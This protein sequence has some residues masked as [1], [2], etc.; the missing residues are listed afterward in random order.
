MK[1]ISPGQIPRSARSERSA[2]SQ[3]VTAGSI[4]APPSSPIHTRN[5]FS[6]INEDTSINLIMP[7]SGTSSARNMAE[8]QHTPVTSSNDITLQMQPQ[9]TILTS[10][11]GDEPPSSGSLD[12]RQKDLLLQTHTKAMSDCMAGT[13]SMLRGTFES[14]KECV[15]SVAN[16]TQDNFQQLLSEVREMRNERTVKVVICGKYKNLNK[17]TKYKISP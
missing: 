16:K 5:R 12:T 10:G 7:E 3:T 13:M 15:M 1:V 2:Q 14:V 17:I 4:E 6:R 8:F 9:T 11:S